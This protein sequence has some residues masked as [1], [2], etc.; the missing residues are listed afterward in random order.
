MNPKTLTLLF[1]PAAMI[2]A[3]CA[4]EGA[5]QIDS[6]GREV[7]TS[8]NDVDIQNYNQAATQ[9]VDSMLRS[10]VLTQLSDGQPGPLIIELDRVSNDTTERIDVD[11]VTDTVRV[12][13]L[14]S[15]QATFFTPD[16]PLAAADRLAGTEL[17]QDVPTADYTL[18]GR[19]TNVA[20]SAG[21]TR[22]QTFV[23]T[24]TLSDRNGITRWADQ[25]FI[26]KQ[27]SRNSV[28]LS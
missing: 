26:T 6:G 1:V 13:T 5:R 7:I 15:G 4:G 11:L 25:V 10:G 20:N 22:Q 27:G 8:V 9:L 28:G 14:K 2:V 19:I 16:A 17:D 12:E 21:R 23:F 18:S 24:L 3:G